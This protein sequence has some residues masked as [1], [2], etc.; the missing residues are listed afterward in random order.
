VIHD[1]APWGRIVPRSDI[2]TP[3]AMDATPEIS[4]DATRAW[5][6]LTKAA[7]RLRSGPPVVCL[8]FAEARCWTLMPRWMGS[9]TLSGS[10][11]GGVVAGCGR[12]PGTQRSRWRARRGC[13]SAA[14]RGVRPASATRTPPAISPDTSHASWPLCAASSV[15]FGSSVPEFVFREQEL[16]LL[17]RCEHECWQE[18][19]L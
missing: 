2:M 19:R 9:R 4:G 10:G 8:G 11:C 5:Q 3:V 12:S 7:A 18:E 13:A 17:A 15:P 14:G 6:G 1:V 16:R